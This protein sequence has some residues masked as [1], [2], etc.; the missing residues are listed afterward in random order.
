MGRAYKTLND[1]TF[2][3]LIKTLIF[4]SESLGNKDTCAP[5]EDQ[6]CA[7][8]DHQYEGIVSTTAGIFLF[9]IS[10]DKNDLTHTV[11]SKNIEVLSVIIAAIHKIKK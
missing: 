10:V 2:L 7:E 11:L 4:H 8:K 1:S 6:F 9:S 3:L 5:Y